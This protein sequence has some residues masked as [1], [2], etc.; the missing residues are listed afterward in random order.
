M[1]CIAMISNTTHLSD[2]E[3]ISLQKWLN[4]ATL[5]AAHWLSLAAA[6]TFAIMAL[7]VGAVGSGTPDILCAAAHDASPLG[8][9]APMY[10]LMSA[11][12]LAPWLKLISSRRSG[13]RLR[14]NRYASPRSSHKGR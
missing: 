12:H 7:L 2:H 5:G 9:M 10:W 8:G 6:P 1:E 13:I 3:V 4:A 11:F 14:P